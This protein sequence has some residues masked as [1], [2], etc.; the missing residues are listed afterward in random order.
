LAKQ[1][2]EKIQENIRTSTLEHAKYNSYD[3]NAIGRTDP[4]RSINRLLN[5][6]ANGQS[7][8]PD[9]K[10]SLEN[11]S[12]YSQSR[13]GTSYNVSGDGPI[14]KADSLYRKK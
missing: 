8:S 9:L 2:E 12:K 3:P 10:R 13:P 6:Y 7:L 14:I 1:K 5:K 11:K 4:V